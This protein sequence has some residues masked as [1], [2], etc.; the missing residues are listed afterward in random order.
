MTVA[1]SAGDY[2]AQQ[3][4]LGG[5]A[6]TWY[7]STHVSDRQCPESLIKH[8]YPKDCH[9]YFEQVQV[10][11]GMSVAASAGSHIS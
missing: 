5:A 4:G 7:R 8:C 11:V 10:K 1:G 6:G 9:T 2:V 3:D